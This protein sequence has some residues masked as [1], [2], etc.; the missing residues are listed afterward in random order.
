MNCDLTFDQCD[1]SSTEDYIAVV[2]ERIARLKDASDNVVSVHLQV[3]WDELPVIGGNSY[4]VPGTDRFHDIC[5]FVIHCFHLHS[6]KG[7]VQDSLLH[8]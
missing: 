7:E 4:I 2:S 6:V 8:V 3:H 5:T 1:K